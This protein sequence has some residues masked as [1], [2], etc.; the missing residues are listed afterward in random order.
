M[1]GRSGLTEQQ[2][3]RLHRLSSSSRSRQK[4][5]ARPLGA[6]AKWRLRRA[7]RS[8]QQPALSHQTPPL[9]PRPPQQQQQQRQRKLSSH[10]PQRAGISTPL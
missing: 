6:G 8:K 9:S 2:R 5:A 7:Q 4:R 10:R 1:S 3:G